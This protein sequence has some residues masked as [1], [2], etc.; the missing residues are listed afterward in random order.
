M[1]E[2][3]F[4]RIKDDFFIKTMRNNL[5]QKYSNFEKFIDYYLCPTFNFKTFFRTYANKEIFF[6]TD[7]SKKPESR[8]SLALYMWHHKSNQY[9]YPWAGMCP[10]DPKLTRGW[11]LN[12]HII[13]LYKMCDALH[14]KDSAP[15]ACYYFNTIFI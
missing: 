15:I 11:M 8:T 9:L 2:K 1:W 4:Q 6:L 7:E 3:S 14:H 10:I 12:I 5:I 13:L